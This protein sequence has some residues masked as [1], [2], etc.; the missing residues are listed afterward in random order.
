MTEFYGLQ[1]YEQ[2]VQ[3]VDTI[4]DQDDDFKHFSFDNIKFASVTI[5]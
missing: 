3:I 4:V 1:K 2:I 5:F